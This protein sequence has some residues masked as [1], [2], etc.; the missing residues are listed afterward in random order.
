M[1]ILKIAKPAEP[2]ICGAAKTASPAIERTSKAHEMDGG[3]ARDGERPALESGAVKAEQRE[4]LRKPPS[5]AIHASM[6]TLQWSA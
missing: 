4:A 1:D 2:V 5:G 6:I 3:R